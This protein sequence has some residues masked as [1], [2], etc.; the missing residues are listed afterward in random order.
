[1]KVYS[2]RPESVSSACRRRIA[3]LL[4]FLLFFHEDT[5]IVFPRGDVEQSRVRAIRRRVPVR[6]A[7]NSGKR[8]RIF[9]L[10]SLDGPAFGI[11]SAGPVHL[12]KGITGEEL[13]VRAIED[14]KEPVTIRP[15]HEL[16]RA[17]VP[18]RIDQNGDLRRI[19]IVRIVGREL[20]KPLEL[21]GI[22]SESDDG[23]GVKVIAFALA[24]IPIGSGIPGASRSG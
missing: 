22:G 14:I 1:M 21:A 17:A 3:G 5:R 8:R 4:V 20:K 23:I 7:L 12:H 11:E 6:P 15:H 9:R 10:G 2:G 16:A 13:S 19:V 18:I 24:G